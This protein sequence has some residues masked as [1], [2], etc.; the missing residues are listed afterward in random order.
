MINT[1]NNI[2][3]DKIKEIHKNV[4]FSISDVKK[5]AELEEIRVLFLGK[6]GYI[7]QIIEQMRNMT[8]EEKRSTGQLIN[9]LKN[10]IEANL[11]RKFL[12]I[13]AEE[14]EIRL[15][16]EK[17]D[18]TL[19]GRRISN[20]VT[21]HPIIEIINIL[22]ITAIDLGFNFVDGN[23]IV[24]EFFN[25]EALNIPQNHPARQ[26]QDTLYIKN[27]PNALLRT[28]TSAVQ[29]EYGSLVPPPIKIASVGRVYRA[30]EVD[31]THSPMFHQIEM[32]HIDKDIS[33]ANLK[34]CC[35]H[36]I[37][38]VFEKDINDIIFRFRTSYFPFTEPSIEID[39]GC[40]KDDENN[41]ILASNKNDVNK[42]LELGGAGIIHQKVLQNMNIN[43][44]EWSGFALG[45]GIERMAMLKKNITDIRHLYEGDI[46]LMKN[47]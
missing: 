5:S 22:K 47:W 29:V 3:L 31:Q 30:D 20:H 34:Y 17:I 11:K 32:M 40:I 45:F 39:I 27:I 8:H 4:E 15:K 33:I 35:T 28:H 9:I 6:K 7:S 43:P 37:S 36:I 44:Q 38:S 12:I 18:I 10:E 23:E 14:E 24:S 2:L 46:R 13:S 41:I 19:P 25:F 16:N 26:M 42:W 21:K 1:N